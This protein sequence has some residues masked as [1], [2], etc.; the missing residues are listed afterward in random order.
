MSAIIL[1]SQSPRRKQLLEWAEVEFEVVV[2]PTDETYPD[3]LPIPEV[4]IYIARKKAEAI[5]PKSNGKLIIAADTIVVIG[6]EIIN[7]PSNREE[8]IGMLS[9]LN[10]RTHQVI[11][12]VVMMKGNKQTS[13]AD[14][15][16]VDF[17][18]L[19]TEQ[20]SFYVDKYKPYDKAGAYAIQEWIGVVGI[21][22]I[23]GDFYNVMGLPVS[24]VL[25]TLKEFSQE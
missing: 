14:I 9:K 25:Q 21:K 3:H 5:L 16:D 4:P 1:A 8:A 2:H 23:R 18:S 19:T 20:I 12:G 6:E 13:F 10:G 11:T 15:T 7:K 24:R 17:H 22:G